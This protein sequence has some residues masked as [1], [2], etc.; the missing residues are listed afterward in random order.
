MYI[1]ICIYIADLVKQLKW[2]D[3]VPLALGMTRYMY[4]YTYIYTYV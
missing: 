1:Y 3:G 4:I 2:C